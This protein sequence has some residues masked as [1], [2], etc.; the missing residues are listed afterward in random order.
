MSE[1]SGNRQIPA[2]YS[3]FLGTAYLGEQGTAETRQPTRPE[4][5]PAQ[6]DAPGKESDLSRLWTLG[7]SVGSAFAAPWL[8][9]MVHGT[10]VPFRHS[11]FEIGVDFGLVSGTV[12]VG[13]YSLYPF[14]H[15]AF[16]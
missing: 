15:Y 4:R 8:I 7:V 5:L 10:I 6:Q 16:F 12:D 9:G 13:Y 1:V 2:V 11:F 14:V 3:Q